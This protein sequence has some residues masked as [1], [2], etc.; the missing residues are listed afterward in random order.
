MTLGHLIP[1]YRQKWC[2]TTFEL[3]DSVV[4]LF[5]ELRA[6]VPFSTAGR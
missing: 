3:R 5:R 2:F 6:S 1:N 4:R